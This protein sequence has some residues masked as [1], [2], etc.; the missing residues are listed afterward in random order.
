MTSMRRRLVGFWPERS[1]LAAR[2]LAP[3]G[4]D[5][6]VATQ[7]AGGAEL[8]GKESA[9]KGGGMGGCRVGRRCG[10]GGGGGIAALSAD[11][12]EEET[13]AAVAAAANACFFSWA[14][15]RLSLLLLPRED[16]R[17]ET[18][19]ERDWSGRRRSLLLR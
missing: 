3:S 16:R 5:T 12:E 9:A 17:R 15:S 7:G 6:S 8:A 4:A 18:F 19:G 2:L 13:G 14:L 1:S 11:V 10:M